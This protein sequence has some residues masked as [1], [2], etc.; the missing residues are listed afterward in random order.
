VAIVTEDLR[1]SGYRSGQRTIATGAAMNGHY[2]AAEIGIS[3]W[4]KASRDWRNP[5]VG[6]CRKNGFW[7][8]SS[9]A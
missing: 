4:G 3:Q 8:G 7:E 1:K 9:V 2:R 6:W 5:L